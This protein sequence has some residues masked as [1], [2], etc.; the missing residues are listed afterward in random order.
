MFL[1]AELVGAD[2]RRTIA[3]I[4]YSDETGQFLVSCF[5]ENVPVELV[6]YLI[7]EGRQCL[8]P[9]SKA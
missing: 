5:E 8:P 1:E 6:E 2:A 3:E 9:S 4:F 7:A